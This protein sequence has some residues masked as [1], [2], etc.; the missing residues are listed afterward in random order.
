MRAGRAM[1]VLVI[2]FLFGALV[3]YASGGSGEKTT[4][5]SPQKA[6]TIDILST[7][8]PQQPAVEDVVGP[9]LKEKTGVTPNLVPHPVIEGA[10]SGMLVQALIAANN[11]PHIIGQHY[12]PPQF[13]SQ[14]ILHDQGLLWSMDEATLRKYMPN[15]SKRMDQWGD[16]K[17]YLEQTKTF[18]GTQY[19]LGHSFD[20]KVLPKFKTTYGNERSYTLN[21]GSADNYLL[22]FRDDILKKIYPNARTHKEQ[23]QWFVDK[24]NP[25][26]PLDPNPYSDIPLKNNEDLYN[27]L[28]QAKAIIDRDNLKDGAG[29]DKMIPAQINS[30]QHPQSIAYAGPTFFGVVWIEPQMYRDAGKSTYNWSAPSFKAAL[31]WYNK[32]FNEGLLDPELFI[33]PDVQLGEE[34][35]R[36][37][38]AVFS[39]WSNFKPARDYA[40]QN[41]LPYSYRAWGFLPLTLKNGEYDQTNVPVSYF[42][43]FTSLMVTKTVKEADLPQVL[44][45][46][47]YHFTEEFD[48]L[49]AWGPSSF[50]TG[51]GKDRRFKPEYKALEDFQAYGIVGA[52]GTKD[53]YYYGITAYSAV[54]VDAKAYDYASWPLSH[55][56]GAWPEAPQYV[57]PVQKKAGSD[58][59]QILRVYTRA[60]DTAPRTNYY[61]QTGWSFN[62]LNSLP[63]TA[64]LLYA[65]FGAQAVSDGISA[66]VRGTPADFE[67]NWND[68]YMKYFRENEYD[69]L[70]A[71]YNAKWK[72]IYDKYVKQY[73]K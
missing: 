30:N 26:K 53:G 9:V 21:A 13:E 35:T 55:F 25:S 40:T 20:V 2:F 68:T 3:L 48:V 70:D 62:D 39:N 49:T 63:Y 47:D 16:M 4:T 32:L 11:L 8:P 36:G 34:Y 27:Y 22:G 24:W 71:E 28:K 29:R 18:N 5:M 60:A 72:E 41:N 7:G 33:K 12:I 61:P 31:K 64:K 42:S 58:T 54:A 52:P 17:T 67:K 15:F 59:D 43:H 37:R 50:W 6:I 56:F 46:L 44:N 66:V 73:W 38:F 19:V 51:T 14:K 65:W 57:Y 23:E 10:T 69:K 1:S 45:W